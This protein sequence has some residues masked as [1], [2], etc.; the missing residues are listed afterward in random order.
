ML[1]IDMHTHVMPRHMPDLA[2]KFIENC[3]HKPLTLTP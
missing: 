1:K 2:K 3:R